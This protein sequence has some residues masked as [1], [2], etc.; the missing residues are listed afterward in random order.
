MVDVK[1]ASIV[2]DIVD[3]YQELVTKEINCHFDKNDLIFEYM[4]DGI[5]VLIKQQQRNI[6]DNFISLKDR[7]INCISMSIK[8]KEIVSSFLKLKSENLVNVTIDFGIGI[9]AGYIL[10]RP[11]VK[12]KS[13]IYIGSSINRSVKIGDA[14]DKSK[15]NIGI[16]IE[17]LDN[18][19]L[20]YNHNKISATSLDRVK[21]I[22]I[23][24]YEKFNKN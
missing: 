20:E 12:R 2:A 9:S 16:D 15:G 10:E 4:G 17:P 8:I 24:E 5:L 23:N 18:L 3:E 7:L 11:K 21:Y 22:N 1:N 6:N 14:Q 13:N 19:E